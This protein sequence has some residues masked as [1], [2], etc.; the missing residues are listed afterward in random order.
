MTDSKSRQKGRGVGRSRN[1]PEFT[2]EKRIPVVRFPPLDFQGTLL[3]WY[4]I[5]RRELPWRSRPEE[6]P[7]PYKVWLSEIMLQQTTVKAVLPYYAAFLER[8]PAVHDLASASREEV[9]A[10]WAGLGYYSR[11]R[12]LHDCARSLAQNGFPTTEAGL[13]DLPGIGNYTAAAIAA[14]AF[15]QKAT[16]VDGNV[17]RV[18]ARLF[19]LQAPLPAAKPLLRELASILTPEERAGDYAQA[20]MDLGATICTP[21]SP[22][23]LSCP[24]R[25]FCGVVESGEAESY[26]RKAAKSEKPTR[27]GTAFV[28][29]RDWPG[30]PSVLLRKRPDKGLLGGMMEVP[31]SAWLAE[32]DRSGI[33]RLG[34]SASR[35][36]DVE[37]HA[38]Y[39]AGKV[40]H[41]FTHFHLELRVLTGNGTHF[42]ECAGKGDIWAPVAEL[43]KFALPSVMRKVIALGVAAF[44]DLPQ[45]D[46]KAPINASKVSIVDRS[47]RPSTSS[48]RKWR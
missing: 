7:D 39:E 27:L 21:R 10:A 36:D 16:V 29:L 31:C 47:A 15:G 32:P 18:L 46:G 2:P 4:D 5:A 25:K 9:M 38:V 11:A 30:S 33:L 28:L 43:D 22:K 48:G 14:I 45:T 20:M 3:N 44:A 6:K 37:D 13:R 41:T 40:S 35:G 17:E 34:M 8:W 19:A 26:P 1:A 42:P 24:V 23:C 12:N